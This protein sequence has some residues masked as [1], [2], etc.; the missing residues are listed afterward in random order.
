MFSRDEIKEEFEEFKICSR[1]LEAE[2]EV[3][4]DQQESKIKE[5]TSSNERMQMEL[6]SLR[7]RIEQ[8]NSSSHRQLS[9][10]EDEFAKVKHSND[11][12]TKYIRELEQLNDDLER[13]KR[14]YNFPLNNCQVFSKP[15]KSILFLSL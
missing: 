14:F 13:A 8:Q 12:L 5:L 7:E 15:Y 11:A 6:E 10:L 1:E 4:L 9:E 3:Q 2:Y